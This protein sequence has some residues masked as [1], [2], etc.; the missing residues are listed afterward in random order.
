MTSDIIQDQQAL[1]HFVEQLQ[2]EHTLAF[3]LEAD[4]LHH[5]TEKVCLIQVSNLSQTA[6]I[7]P[8]APVDL[9]PLAPV[10]ANREVRKVFHGADYDMRSLYRDFGFEVCNLFDT[11]I[12]CQFRVR[13]K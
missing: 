2:G 8:L 1:N 11:M 12:A 7:D 9:S 5:Y 13:R 4:S 6:L 10:L 3:D